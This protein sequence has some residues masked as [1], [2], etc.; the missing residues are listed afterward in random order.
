[1]AFEIVPLLQEIQAA[2][3]RFY[4]VKVLHTCFMDYFTLSLQPIVF[5]FK[6][7]SPHFYRPYL[8]TAGAIAVIEG[9]S[10]VSI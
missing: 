5:A 6:E 4:N 8:Y 1:M 9:R 7:F 2:S 10:T 3:A